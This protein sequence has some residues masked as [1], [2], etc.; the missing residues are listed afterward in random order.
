MIRYLALA[1][2]LGGQAPQ[3]DI[4]APIIEGLTS[5]SAGHCSEAFVAW[6][7]GWTGPDD[8][9][10][11]EQL[12]GSCDVLARFGKLQGYDVLRVVDVGPHVR[13]VY[14]VLRYEIQ[15]VYMMLVAYQPTD[16]WKVITVNWNTIADKVLPATVTPAERP[17]P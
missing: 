11:Q 13:R 3:R 4:P 1:A 14:L 16:A 5:L 10:K 15:P 9:G 8:V 17:S 2:V 12:R 6:S 7:R